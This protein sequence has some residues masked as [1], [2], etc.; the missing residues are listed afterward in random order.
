ML[1]ALTKIVILLLALTAAG[2]QETLDPLELEDLEDVALTLAF[3]INGDLLADPLH[4]KF[5]IYEPG[6]RD[7]YLD[8]GHGNRTAHVPGG[9]YDL[10]IRYKNDAAIKEIVRKEIE[11]VGEMFETIDFNIQ[12][13]SLSM[14]ITSGGL[15][16]Q[17]YSGRFTL[18][19]AGKR[20]TVLARKR[21]G[22]TLIIRRGHYDIEVSYRDAQGLKSTWLENYYLEDVRDETVE[23]GLPLARLTINLLDDGLPLTADMATWR[24]Y[25]PGQR[26]AFLAER[27]AG[28]AIHLEP[29]RY[30]I[31]A[32]RG[33]GEARDERWLVGLELSGELERQIEIGSPQNALR[34]N[35]KHENQ[36]LP[37]AWFSVYEQGQSAQALLSAS[38]SERVTLANGTYD[39]GCFIR[40]GGFRSEKR[41]TNVELSDDMTLD[42]D[43]EAR[44]ASLRVRPRL[45]R[46]PETS[47]AGPNLMILLDSSGGMRARSGNHSRLETVR[48]ALNDTLADISGM[49]INLGLRVFGAALEGRRDCRDSELLVSPAADN[50]GA[51]RASLDR[52]QGN[53]T[54]PLA[55]AIE[56][57]AADLPQGA[58]NAIVL[59]TSS[60]EGCG[61]QP[62]DIAARLI[63]DGTLARIHVIGLGIERD[64]IHNLDCI[65]DFHAASNATQLKAA[66]QEIARE[67]TRLDQGTYAVFK[68]NRPNEWITG[69][70]IG[71]RVL[72]TEGRYDIQIT[73]PD[74]QYHWQDVRIIGDVDSIAGRKAPRTR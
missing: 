29:G 68:A 33:T 53:G 40:D 5:F 27:G 66:L 46:S 70:V 58:Q 2:A 34:I 9:I 38:N 14:Q 49:Q 62:C 32:F 16:I 43:L 7:E 23:L 21:P 51:I 56:R 44:P 65:G 52:L 17:S 36:L 28:E 12:L 10:V 13:A 1:R 45:A 61:G 54:S 47:S 19:P 35:I 73:T 57:A 72:L 39:I 3:T 69:G 4:A 15:P 55:L 71:R 48:M 6:E 67:T 59:L 74:K 30:D 11:L 37:G 20:T 63:H 31:G 64:Q 41:L 25:K 24:V 50:A 22:E 26:S 42:V 18:H 8:W 60:T